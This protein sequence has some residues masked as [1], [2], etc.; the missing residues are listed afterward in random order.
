MFA[1]LTDTWGSSIAPHRMG[2][3]LYHSLEES[4]KALYALLGAKKEDTLVFTSSGAEAINQV[5]ISVYLEETRNKGKN[6]YIVSQTDEAPIQM[7]VSR[8][9]QMGCVGKYIKP[10][11]LGKISVE[12]IADAIT[13]RTALVSLSWANGLTG[14]INPVADIAHLCKSRGIKLHLDATH[15]LGKLYYDLADIDADFISFNGSHLHAPQGTGGLWIK[16]GVS[17]TPLI[18]GSAEQAGYR[19]GNIN[20]PAFVAMGHAAREA[21]ETRDLFCMETARLRDRLERGI[22]QGW[23]EATV[24]FKDSDRLPHCCTLTFPGIAN[25]ALLFALSRQELFG[26][27]G[28]GSFPQLSLILQASD[29]PPILAHTALSVSLS[30]ETLEEEIDRATYLIIETARRLRRLS[31]QLPI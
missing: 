25:E 4:Y 23:P 22:A 27:I 28:G 7:S 6:Q 2:Q 14:V 24:L 26:S 10:D 12:A 16:A 30:R 13:P 18:I 29:I 1:F 20:M 5:F 8:L 19:A 17:C 3:E 15:V 31:T 21:L 9:Q 11:A